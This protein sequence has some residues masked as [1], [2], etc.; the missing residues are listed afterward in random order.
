MRACELRMT[1][2]PC[3]Y[4]CATVL[5]HVLGRGDQFGASPVWPLSTSSSPVTERLRHSM[6]WHAP[7]PSS[8]GLAPTLLEGK[9]MY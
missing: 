4:L 6:H 9:F 3:T 7:Q 1:A 5:P 8:P 2:G